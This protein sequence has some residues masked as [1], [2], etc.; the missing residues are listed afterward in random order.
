[1]LGEAE[2]DCP[3]STKDS[4]LNEKNKKKIADNNQYGLPT[5]EAKEK[6]VNGKKYFV[7]E[8]TY[9]RPF[10]SDGDTVYM[11]VENPS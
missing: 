7:F 1:M 8:G 4:D 9:Y 10:S 3:K 6:T 5:E 2:M 11:S